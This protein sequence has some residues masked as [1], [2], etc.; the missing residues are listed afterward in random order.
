MFELDEKLRK[1][2]FGEVLVELAQEDD[3]LI[4]ISGDSHNSTGLRPL[5]AADS[6]KVVNI[7]IQ[8]Q[9]GMAF[10][11]GLAAVGMKPFMCGFAP[12][13]TLRCVEQF[14]TF[15]AYPNLNV[16]VLCAFSGL[17]GCPDGGVTH[18]GLEDY[19][20][21]RLFPNTVIVVP[22]DYESSKVITREIYKHEGPAMITIGIK[23]HK[24]FDENYHFEIGKA[25]PMIDGDD[26]TI[27]SC[28]EMLYRALEVSEEMKE[29][30]VSVRVIEMPC[31]KP[32]DE[33][34]IIKAAKETGAIVTVE[35]HQIMGGLGTAV[36]EVLSEN[37]P[38]VLKRV[39]LKDTFAESGDYQG[40]IEKYGLTKE[41]VK[42]A[43]RE[44]IAK[45]KDCR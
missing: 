8:E 20:V 36:A 30:G 3:K 4:A 39:G 2:G 38:A 24:I 42:S 28:G 43:V 13:V 33:A 25:N 5:E 21:M 37:C 40:L 18:M 19:N 34:A 22:A 1:D 27:I 29:E 10:A 14:R 7:G 32:I 9:N 45:K 17:L 11:A 16:K 15:V 44:V 6:A 31:I 12:F 26:V 41:D 35:D 23:A